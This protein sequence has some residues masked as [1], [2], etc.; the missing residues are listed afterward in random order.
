MLVLSA[1]PLLK[2]II[3]ILQ[4]VLFIFADNLEH[5]FDGNLGGD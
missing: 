4:S 5:L 2:I 1:S 3:I